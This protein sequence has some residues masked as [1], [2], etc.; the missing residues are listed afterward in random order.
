MMLIVVSSKSVSVA[1]MEAT[2]RDIP[3]TRVSQ[4]VGYLQGGEFRRCL[5]L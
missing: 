4:T 5:W 2:I 1:Q 3:G